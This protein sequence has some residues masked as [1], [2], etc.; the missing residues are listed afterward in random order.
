MNQRT[1][2]A[3]LL[4]LYF[5]CEWFKHYA[6]PGRHH[7]DGCVAYLLPYLTENDTYRTCDLLNEQT[8]LDLFVANAAY[9]LL[10]AHA[11]VSGFF[12]A[13]LKEP[14]LYWAFAYGAA[15]V[16]TLLGK[17]EWF[18]FSIST[19]ST[20]TDVQ[21]VVLAVA[22]VITALLLVWQACLRRIQYRLLQIPVLL[23][24]FVL[25]LFYTTT[26]VAYH[27][28][29]AIMAGFLSLC[30]TRFKY[31]MNRCVHAVCMGL[32]VQGMNYYTV[33][34]IFLF[35]I[36][37]TPPPSFVYMCWLCAL[38][39]LALGLGNKYRAMYDYG[40]GCCEKRETKGSTTDGPTE[41]PTEGPMDGPMVPMIR[42]LVP[43]TQQ[44]YR[45]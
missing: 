30:F 33:K 8:N 43:D 37:Y 19:T 35:N 10:C 36:D 1:Y 42:R 40:V 11:L 28:H 38:F 29:H 16:Y 6:P 7:F 31:R 23:Y 32:F 9:T 3:V 5:A 13:R 21:L 25:F 41:G 17:S 45:V 18:Q 24:G 2:M 12:P 4:H 34:E 27:L 39:P 22:L 44:Y 15:C 20:Y 14:W 26:S